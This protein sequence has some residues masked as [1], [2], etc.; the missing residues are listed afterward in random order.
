MPPLGGGME[1]IMIENNVKESFFKRHKIAFIIILSLIPLILITCFVAFR[2]IYLLTT[3]KIED[4]NGPDDYSV[5]TITEEEIKNAVRSDYRSFVSGQS[6]DGEHSD[7]EDR[8]LEDVDYDSTGY[9]ANSLNGILIANATKTDKDK[10]SLE[11]TSE[12]Y[13]GNA[14]IFVFIDDELY[15]VIEINKTRRVVLTDVAG[16]TVYVKVACED[17]QISIDVERKIG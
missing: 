9:V 8:A 15:G 6:S 5:V 17:A 4:T 13:A 10:V 7:V 3:G 1:I 14:Q 16:K 12:V 2:L 11:I